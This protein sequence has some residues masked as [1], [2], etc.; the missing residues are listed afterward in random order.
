MQSFWDLVGGLV[1]FGSPDFI[2]FLNGYFIEL[3]IGM[4]E[5]NYLNAVVDVIKD[6]IIEDIP[7]FF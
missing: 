3:G 6:Y 2:A 7:E 5:K 1:T 4:F